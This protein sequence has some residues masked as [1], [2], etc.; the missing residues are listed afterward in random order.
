MREGQGFKVG[1]EVKRRNSENITKGTNSRNQTHCGFYLLSP[2]PHAS[3]EMKSWIHPTISSTSSL[4]QVT[5]EEVSYGLSLS[6]SGAKGY[7]CL[8]SLS[9]IS[10][11]L[12]PGH[13]SFSLP[14]IIP[15]SHSPLTLGFDSSSPI[16]STS[17]SLRETFSHQ[18]RPSFLLFCWRWI[19]MRCG[20]RKVIARIMV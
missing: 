4:Y 20:F 5:L 12:L 6:L 19:I 8:F 15:P 3:P 11:L 1:A 2:N 9:C 16:I 14:V 18:P 13:F 17:W 10:V 7:M